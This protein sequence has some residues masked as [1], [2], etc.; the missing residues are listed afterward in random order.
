MQVGATLR[1]RPSYAVHVK[2]TPTNSGALVQIQ[3]K[4]LPFSPWCRFF[5]RRAGVVAPYI[6]RCCVI[7]IVLFL[8]VKLSLWRGG[9]H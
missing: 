5:A 4:F 2:F 6:P 1:G 7:F 8:W 9:R 3:H